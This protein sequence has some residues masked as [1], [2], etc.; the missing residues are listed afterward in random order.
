[1]NLRQLV[2]ALILLACSD[3]RHVVDPQFAV[4][5]APFAVAPSPDTLKRGE[6]VQ[7][8]ATMNGHA[9]KPVR[10]SSADPSV[11]T[12]SSSG[13]VTAVAPGEANIV[14]A[15]G[16]SR[17]AARIVVLPPIGVVLMIGDGMGTGALD[18]A[19][20]LL[21]RALAMESLP[22][23]GWQE[24]RSLDRE[25]TESAAAATALATG[26]RTLY[27]YVGLGPD[28]QPLQTVLELAESKGMAT[29]MAVTSS[30]THAT[31]AAFAAH[32]RDRSNQREIARQI[33]FSNIDVL[34]GGGTQWFTPDMRA[35]L[36]ANGARIGLFY[37]DSMPRL[38]AFDSPRIPSLSEM[39]AS[40]LDVLLRDPDGFFLMVEGSQIDWASHNNNG[41]WVARETADFDAAVDVVARMLAN[42]S[43]TLLVVTADHETGGL[44]LESGRYVFTTTGHTG[45]D[46]PVFARGA[47][48][49]QLAG[50]RQNWEIGK[51]L[52]DVI[53]AD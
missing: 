25:V 8:V 23:R 38:L 43:N 3:P 52:I 18:A 9:I 51:L 12:V 26:V 30:V 2:P 44:S 1:M 46:V 32:L 31:P 15:L 28:G 45:A 4:T 6:A 49:N 5:Q 37:P 16:A 48:S 14:A 21:G 29:G 47:Y 40:A 35:R 22:I 39:T 33:S 36:D 34:L 20:A 42:R 53:R 50:L 7:L 17:A 10:W 11:A 13:L 24:T 41:D 27:G 19:R